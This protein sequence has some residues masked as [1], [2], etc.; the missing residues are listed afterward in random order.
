[1]IGLKLKE[2]EAHRVLNDL[3]ELELTLDKVTEQLEEEGVQKSSDPY[4]ALMEALEKK[5]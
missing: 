1:M 4:D 5:M 2:S 3:F